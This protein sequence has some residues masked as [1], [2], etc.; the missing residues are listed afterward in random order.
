M[1]SWDVM[2][3]KVGQTAEYIFFLF[4]FSLSKMII[5]RRWFKDPDAYI[6][7][8]KAL[9]YKTCHKIKGLDAT[10]CAK[11]CERFK[12]STFGTNCTSKGG[13]FKCCIR[14]DAAMCHECR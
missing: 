2:Q 11:D 9:G 7:K 14:R 10:Q 12:L 5:L 1:A 13:L 8:E 3:S 6:A 4:F